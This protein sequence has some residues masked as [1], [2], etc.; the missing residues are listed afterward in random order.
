MVIVVSELI[1]FHVCYEKK[2]C[3][4]HIT[5]L[6]NVIMEIVLHSDITSSKN[7]ESSLFWFSSQMRGILSNDMLSPQS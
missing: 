2:Y 6:H 4:A 7:S 3:K 1:R 5:S